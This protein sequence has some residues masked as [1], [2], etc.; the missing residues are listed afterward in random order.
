MNKT[1]ELIINKW[2]VLR[3][4]CCCP[5]GSI[6]PPE[7]D[8]NV[9]SKKSR[10]GLG[11]SWVTILDWEKMRGK[12]FGVV[13]I[14]YLVLAWVGL[15]LIRIEIWLSRPNNGI[16][17]TLRIENFSVLVRDFWFCR[18]MLKKIVF[19][20]FFWKMTRKL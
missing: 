5:E 6:W 1:I 14:V 11:G 17:G 4:R 3:R 13:S 9:W 12:S 2:I 16:V 10:I 20:E 15:I 7:I 18:N 19:V 8:G